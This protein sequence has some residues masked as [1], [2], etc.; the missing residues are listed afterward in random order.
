MSED[1]WVGRKEF[2]LLLE[3][4]V[5]F[6]NLWDKFDEIDSSGDRRLSVDEFIAGCDLVG[7]T[8]TA[9]EARREFSEIDRTA[10]AMC[11]LMSSVRGV[12]V[13]VLRTTLFHQL[14]HLRC[15]LLPNHGLNPI[16]APPLISHSME[17]WIPESRARLGARLRS[18]AR[19]CC[20][21][22]CCCRA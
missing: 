11:C 7:E 18:R 6:N 3:Y 22:R 15:S 1:G 13:V 19:W 20:H 9:V 5:Y 4:L 2:R 17:K 16:L 10:V 8:M 21:T 14:M 12:R